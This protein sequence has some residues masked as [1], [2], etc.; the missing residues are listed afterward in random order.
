MALAAAALPLRRPDRAAGPERL[1]RHLV[2]LFTLFAV[3][4]AAHAG[5]DAQ[6][7]CFHLINSFSKNYLPYFRTDATE[8]AQQAG[9]ALSNLP[10]LATFAGLGSA[11][12]ALQVQEHSASYLE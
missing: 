8:A 5:V 3:V 10:Y 11:A 7:T 6:G 1:A 9:T 12:L 4:P 2:L